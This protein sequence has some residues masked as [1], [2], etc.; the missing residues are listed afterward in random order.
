MFAGRCLTGA[1]HRLHILT[2]VAG[3]ES[4]ALTGQKIHHMSC[5][6]MRLLFVRVMPAPWDYREFSLLQ[7]PIERDALLYF[8]KKAPVRI[9]DEC[10]TGY[11]LQLLTQIEEF[12]TVCTTEEAK[13]I[14]ETLGLFSMPTREFCLEIRIELIEGLGK[15]RRIEGAHVDRAVT[16]GA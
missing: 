9:Q 16:H 12:L 14:E 7:M 2:R 4:K 3:I 5:E 6:F 1:G 15:F 11:S 13:L 10:R 8:E